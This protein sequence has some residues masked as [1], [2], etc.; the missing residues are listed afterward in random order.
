MAFGT[1]IFH[2]K[3][4][5]KKSKQGTGTRT[6]YGKSKG[7]IKKYRGQGGPKKRVR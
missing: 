2:T 4:K 3:G 1:T 7:S 6:K 5:G